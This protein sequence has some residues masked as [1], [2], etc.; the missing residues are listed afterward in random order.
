LVTL[1]R[2][3]HVDA[4]LRDALYDSMAEA[5]PPPAD[6]TTSSAAVVSDIFDIM[7]LEDPGPTELPPA[8]SE[9]TKAAELAFARMP[10][11]FK[12]GIS[13][14]R[15][16]FNAWHELQKSNRPGRFYIPSETTAAR[17][18]WDDLIKA[19]ADIGEP[20]DA[21]ALLMV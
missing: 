10:A 1:G 12:A 6:L 20:S 9:I 7:N 18:E 13:G 11:A 16:V 17:L 5:Y 4:V 2:A 15:Q 14:P 21:P 19:F 8:S 3:L